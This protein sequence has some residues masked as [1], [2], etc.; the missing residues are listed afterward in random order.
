MDYFSENVIGPKNIIEL[1]SQICKELKICNTFF[2]FVWAKIPL[3][4][5]L[6]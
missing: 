1:S 4:S 2:F 5:D 6:S 3:S